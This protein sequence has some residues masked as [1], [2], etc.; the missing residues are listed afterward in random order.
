M[1]EQNERRYRRLDKARSHYRRTVEFAVA[2]AVAGL[3]GAVLSVHALLAEQDRT[4]P[5][6]PFNDARLKIEYNGTGGD[7]AEA[8]RTTAPARDRSSGAQ[9]ARPNRELSTS[10]KRAERRF[11]SASPSRR[12]GI[13]TGA[14]RPER[15][16]ARVL[17]R[18][19]LAH[20]GMADRT[21]MTPSSTRSA[22]GPESACDPTPLSRP[23]FVEGFARRIRR[24]VA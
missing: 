22:E 18:P 9:N 12:S 1:P 13:P 8:T 3:V 4:S 19:T 5:P 14:K 23:S 20:P 24:V 17:I 7:A 15:H 11:A 21:V 2:V 6:K 10:V 16:G